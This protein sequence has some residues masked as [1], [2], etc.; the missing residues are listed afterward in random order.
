MKI[1]I[2]GAGDIG[3]QLSRRLSQEKHDIVVVES[4]PQKVRRASHQLDAMVIE[5]HGT[6]YQTLE[7][8][9]LSDTE[10]VAAMTNSE[11]V[12]LISCQLAKK[13][14]VATTIARVRNPEFTRP[15]FPLTPQELGVDV[16]IHPERETADAIVRLIRRSGATDI[17]EFEEGRVQLMGVRLEKDSALL[18]TPLVKLGKQFGNPPMRIVAIVRQQDTLI[19]GGRDELEPGDQI[20]V[21]SDPGYVT[22]FVALAGKKDTRIEN[23]MILGGGLIGQ[24]VASTLAKE[25][26]VK[27]IE[28]SAEKSEEIAEGLP[29]TL[30]IHGDGT[31]YDLLAAEGIV[32]M[33]AFVAVTGDDETNIIATLLV[34]HMRIPRTIALV[35]KVDYMPITKTIGMDAV[36]SKQMITVNAVQRYI[37][38]QQVA[39]IASLPGIAAHC[40]EYIAKRKSKILSKPL[41]D[42]EFP[43]HA[44]VGAVLHDDQVLI[45]KGDTHIVEGDRV[46]VF[47]L[48]HALD[49]VEK[50]FT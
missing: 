5:G 50:L 8:A 41:R 45:P 35:N 48:P 15:D 42:I 3:F 19:P 12:N 16:M 39:A 27:I 49:D 20:F 11:E 29:H 37:Q 23:I 46:V 6:S 24:F 22:E 26:N 4:D 31:D 21:I 13:A 25:T 44:I 34:R 9:G 32:D 2:I 17:I 14:G 33:D 7:K 36:V 47:S 1:L 28:S 40:I 10:I 30:I 38:H 18:G 43:R